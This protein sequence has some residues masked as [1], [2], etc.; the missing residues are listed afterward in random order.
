MEKRHTKKKWSIILNWLLVIAIWAS[1]YWSSEIFDGIEMVKARMEENRINNLDILDINYQPTPYDQGNWQ[2][3]NIA[4]EDETYIYYTGNGINIERKN[5]ATKEIEII[6]NRQSGTGVSHFMIFDEYLIFRRGKEIVRMKKDGSK[7]E[8]IYKGDYPIDLKA[9]KD[10]LY[11]FVY[12]KGIYTVDVNGRGLKCINPQPV[13]DMTIYGDRIY[14]SFIVDGEGYVKSMDLNG[15]NKEDIFKAKADNIIVKENGIYYVDTQT[16]QLFYYDGK[17]KRLISKHKIDRFN[18]AENGIYG[19]DI[20]N[21]HN[22]SHEKEYF[23]LYFIGFG[24]E[25]SNEPVII[26]QGRELD[27]FSILKEELYYQGA[28]DLKCEKLVTCKR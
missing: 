4:V 2:N 27:G 10:R 16:N 8:V 18:V 19:M 6:L 25:S 1:I 3:W 5:K 23:I 21:G 12:D 11:F 17:V 15:L 14:Y 7:E 26:D 13:E 22:V 9:Y 20:H 24:E 28:K